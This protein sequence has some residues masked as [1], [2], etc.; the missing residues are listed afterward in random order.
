MCLVNIL[1]LYSSV[2]LFYL[3]GANVTIETPLFSED[4]GND[5]TM[6]TVQVCVRL[7]DIQSGLMRDLVFSLTVDFDSAGMKVHYSK[8]IVR[9]HCT[10]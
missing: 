9:G 2:G 8:Y 7:T 3:T 5:G 1:F 10:K 6:N 4:E